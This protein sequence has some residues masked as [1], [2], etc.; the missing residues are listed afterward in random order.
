ML[1]EVITSFFRFLSGGIIATIILVTI[2][3]FDMKD[4]GLSPGIQNMR[5]GMA[6]IRI[7]GV[8]AGI[9]RVK[10]TNGSASISS[11]SSTA[12][13]IGKLGRQYSTGSSQNT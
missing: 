5:P 3:T 1:Y 10:M 13:I 9:D 11:N 7:T 4:A 8:I 2:M 12:A 6:M